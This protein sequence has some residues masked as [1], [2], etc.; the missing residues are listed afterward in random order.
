MDFSNIT[1]T[2]FETYTG[3]DAPLNFERLKA[4]SI[5]IISRYNLN[6]VSVDCMLILENAIY[7]QI[8]YFVS[9][10]DFASNKIATSKR[11]GNASVNYEVSSNWE[12]DV[13]PMTESLLNQSPCNFNYRGMST[14]CCQC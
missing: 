6:D 9:N 5:S 12:K 3:F 13:A 11:A 7:E 10:K 8:L 14:L 2:G 4:L 1:T